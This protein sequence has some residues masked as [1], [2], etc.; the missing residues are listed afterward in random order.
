MSS[1]IRNPPSLKDGAS[2][3]KWEKALKIWQVVTELP[4]EKQGS[5]VVLVLT[6]KAQ[7]AVLEMDINEIKDKNGV[8]KIL[9]TLG[10]IYKKD[11][12]DMA[13]EKFEQFIHFKRE[14][15]MDINTFITEFER[16]Y[17]QA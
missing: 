12:V 17:S 16:R 5:A 6:G 3:E 9:S 11:T 8:D 15:S 2:F 10:K 7:E 13:Y 14:P 1:N 4:A